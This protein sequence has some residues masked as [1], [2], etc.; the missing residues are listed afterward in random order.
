MKKH[1]PLILVSIF[2]LTIFTH[3]EL[4]AENLLGVG[5]DKQIGKKAT[6]F[7]AK[8]I[9]DKD[10][11]LSSFK[12]KPVIVNFWATW[13]PYCRQERSSLN[14]LYRN[15]KD[16]GL[17]VI[18]ISTGESKRTVENYLKNIPADFLVLLDKEREIAQAYGV[19]GLPTSFVINRD[20]VVRYKSTGARDWLSADSKKQI[21]EILK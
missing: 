9:S 20:G 2:M 17:I 1:L 21:E 16:K 8:D 6:E 10:V 3:G 19:F 11:M 4:F 13:C 18:S 14:S 12:G 7:T 15:Y 5:I